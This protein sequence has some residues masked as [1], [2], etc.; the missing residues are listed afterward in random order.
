MQFCKYNKYDYYDL[1]KSY[2]K[3]DHILIDQYHLKFQYSMAVRKNDTNQ[4]NS[5]KQEPLLPHSLTQISYASCEDISL[6]VHSSKNKS[7]FISPY[8][9]VYFNNQP[10]VMFPLQKTSP[11]QD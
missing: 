8:Y 7:H 1:D 9:L 10:G 2:E 5:L 11:W 4:R 6:S 3:Y